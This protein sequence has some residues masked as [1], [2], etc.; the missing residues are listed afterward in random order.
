MIAHGFFPIPA[1]NVTRSAPITARGQIRLS[2]TCPPTCSS[3]L[4]ALV[5][6]AKA[7][8]PLGFEEGE[9]NWKDMAEAFGA[10]GLKDEAGRSPA[11][12]SS[13]RAWRMG[14]KRG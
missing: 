7:N 4:A 12:K 1:P 2:T 9:P 10:A 5:G 11:A 8:R 14:R 3:G 13:E 6:I